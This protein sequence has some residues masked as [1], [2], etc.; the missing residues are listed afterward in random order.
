VCSSGSGGRSGA[1]TLFGNRADAYRADARFRASGQE[2]RCP[3]PEWGLGAQAERRAWYAL[4]DG[5]GA[6]DSGHL[7]Q[8]YVEGTRGHRRS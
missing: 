3:G 4:N 7:F 1:E 2:A 6:S 8:A 5:M